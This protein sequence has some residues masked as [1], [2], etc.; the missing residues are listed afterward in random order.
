[1]LIIC[2]ARYGSHTPNFWE[3]QQYAGGDID[4]CVVENQFCYV[5]EPKST[6]ENT[7]MASYSMFPEPKGHSTWE[8]AKSYVES[9]ASSPQVYEHHHVYIC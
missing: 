6:T 7:T 9:K 4:K 1:M 5:C 3:I 2:L 8:Q